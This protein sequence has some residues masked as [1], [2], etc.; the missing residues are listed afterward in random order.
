MKE[1]RFQMVLHIY[2]TW[3]FHR[4]MISHF[5][6]PYLTDRRGTKFVVLGGHRND[7]ASQSGKGRQYAAE[8]VRSGT[9][10]APR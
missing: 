9:V 5:L 6:F 7:G 2:T 8:K 4:K 1:N 3:H 10:E